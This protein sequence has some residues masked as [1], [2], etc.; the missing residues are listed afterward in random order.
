MECTSRTSATCRSVRALPL[1]GADTGVHTP[2]VTYRM[3]PKPCA[4]IS[5]QFYGCEAQSDERTRLQT[6]DAPG[7]P[8]AGAYRVDVDQEGRSPECT[9]EA[10]AIRTVNDSVLQGQ[11][12]SNGGKTQPLKKAGI[13]VVASF[14][15]QVHRL[16]AEFDGIRVGTVDKS[17]GQEAPV[18]ISS[19]TSSDAEASPRG[20]DF[21]FSVE[22]VNVAA[23]PG[24]ALRAAF[25][26]PKTAA[27]EV[28]R[29]RLRPD[30]Q[31]PVS[32]EIH[33]APVVCIST[34]SR[35]ASLRTP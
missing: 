29:G 21:L 20:L 31:P 12:T 3:R 6:I 35:Y 1:D 26:S 4:R 19:V 17:Q 2:T 13:I 5:E 30:G 22:C 18:S 24:K 27:R 9:E 28:Q 32:I 23:S 33:P 34:P 15:V 10:E 25:V 7:I 16:S 14:N 8:S 11:W